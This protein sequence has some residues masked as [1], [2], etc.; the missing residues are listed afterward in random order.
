MLTLLKNV[1]V[2]DD[3]SAALKIAT[4]RLEAEGVRVLIANDAFLDDIHAFCQGTMADLNYKFSCLMAQEGV[5][6]DL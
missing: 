3:D 6:L 5:S 4:T 1:L 2:I